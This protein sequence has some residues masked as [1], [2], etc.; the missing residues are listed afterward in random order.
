MSTFRSGPRAGFSLLEM[1]LALTMFTLVIGSALR[2]LIDGRELSRATQQRAQ[3]STSAQHALDRALDELREA[4]STVNP[5]PATA[6]GSSTI[7]FQTPLGVAGGV[8][9]WSGMLQLLFED[10]P[11]DSLG[12]GDGDG[13][14]LVD[15]GRLVLVRD[16]GALNE[17]RIT[18]ANDVPRLDPDE[19]LNNLDDDGDGVIDEAGFNIVRNGE[20]F[21]LRLVVSESGP[22]DE[23][24][25]GRAEASIRLRN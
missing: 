4:S 5:D 22:G 21:T 6:Q 10:D 20:I 14:G 1:V 25:I 18:L 19:L 17:R 11:A 15:E 13:D 12:G 8:V 23:R 16:V 3:A 24:E 2:L 9:N 7:Q